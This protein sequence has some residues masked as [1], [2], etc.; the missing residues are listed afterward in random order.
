MV[1]VVDDGGSN[2]CCRYSIEKRSK[3]EGWTDWLTQSYWYISLTSS[4]WL[5]L[6]EQK[7]VSVRCMHCGPAY[8]ALCHPLQSMMCLALWFHG[9]AQSRKKRFISSAMQW[10]GRKLS[11]TAIISRSTRRVSTWLSSVFRALHPLLTPISRLSHWHIH[12]WQQ[13]NSKVTK[14]NNRVIWIVKTRGQRQWW[15]QNSNDNVEEK[16]WHLPQTCLH[17]QTP[18][19]IG[20]LLTEW[21][22]KSPDLS[23]DL[24][25]LTCA[26]W[27]ASGLSRQSVNWQT[28]QNDFDS[29][30]WSQC[31]HSCSWNCNIWC[32]I[33][34]SKCHQNEL[35]SSDGCFLKEHQCQKQLLAGN[36]PSMAETEHVRIVWCVLW[37]LSFEQSEWPQQTSAVCWESKST[38]AMFC[39]G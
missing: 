13:M 11:S 29:D 8:H 36:G 4:A 35:Q 17:R 31:C 3:R 24:C 12:M 33:V 2:D 25:R 20:I 23:P 38:S 21:S 15:S 16:N 18:M 30:C 32:Q 5:I 14:R 34:F 37:I 9:K 10:W 39:E 6:D 27:H 22:I 28:Q 1:A 26:Q 7:R 19:S